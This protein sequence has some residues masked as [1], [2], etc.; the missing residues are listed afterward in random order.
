MYLSVPP[1]QALELGVHGDEL[2]G[3]LLEG[4]PL[5]LHLG[6]GVLGELL[7]LGLGV[8]EDALRLLPGG[9]RRLPVLGLGVLGQLSGLG[10]GVGEDVLRLL[11]GLVQDILALALDL[12]QLLLG[13]GGLL[14]GLLLGVPDGG[15]V[16]V[17]RRLGRLK[18]PV[19]GQGRLRQGPGV[20]QLQGAVRQLFLQPV[21]LL[22]QG[23]LAALQLIDDLHQLLPGEASEFLVRHGCTILFSCS[24]P[25]SLRRRVP[26]FPG[27]GQAPP[28]RLSI[29]AAAV[30][31][32]PT[33]WKN[34]SSRENRHF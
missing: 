8:G 34:V 26:V 30:S 12:P 32:I 15:Q 16:L 1:Q 18:D 28:A 7:G 13:L 14:P 4:L 23:G 2:L 9:L 27:R 10:L 24:A 17:R 3:V 33:W 21:V 25:G 6:L 31:D 19:Q 29:Y 5:L 22:P 20:L 11:P